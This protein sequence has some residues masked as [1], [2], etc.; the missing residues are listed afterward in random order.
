MPEQIRVVVRGEHDVAICRHFE[1]ACPMA[2]LASVQD[3]IE[4]FRAAFDAPPSSVLVS[5]R[6]KHRRGVVPHH[7][8]PGD[9]TLLNLCGK[10]THATNTDNAIFSPGSLHLF[11]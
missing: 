1:V 3:A 10:I 11:A 4:Q 8:A 2:C 7:L 9:V 6:K 5:R